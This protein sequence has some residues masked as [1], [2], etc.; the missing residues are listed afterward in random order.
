MV[1]SSPVPARPAPQ[2]MPKRGRLRARLLMPSEIQQ[3]RVKT[4]AAATGHSSR[5]PC[6]KSPPQPA[7]SRPAQLAGRATPGH[8]NLRLDAPPPRRMP[9]RPG[10]HAPGKGPPPLAPRGVC[11][12]AHVGS[13]RRGREGGGLAVWRLGFPPS[14]CAGA[15]KERDEAVSVEVSETRIST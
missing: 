13:G 8:A 1:S 3:G 11:P 6:H 9:P 4:G 5:E 2:P 12:A 14:G 7:R 15:T 10:L